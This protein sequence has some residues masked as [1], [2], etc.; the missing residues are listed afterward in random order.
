[1]DWL[2]CIKTKFTKKVNMD[3]NLI[4]AL[5]NSSSKRL[6]TQFLLELNE[7]TATSKIS[8]T[9]DSL[10]ELLEAVAISKGYKIYN[11]ECYYSFLK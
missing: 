8:L 11:H 9:Y 3:R 4:N 6:K 2:N 5:T 10:R 1:M 7:D